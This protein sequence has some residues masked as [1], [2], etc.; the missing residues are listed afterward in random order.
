MERREFSVILLTM[1]SLSMLAFDLNIQQAD[2][3][4]NTVYVDDDNVGGPWNGTQAFPYRNI[5]SALGQAASGDTVFVY[6]GTYTEQLFVNKSIS[7]IGQNPVLT[8]LDGSSSETFLIHIFNTTNVI[9]KNF[10]VQNTTP[11][12]ESYGVS[13]FQVREAIIQNL[14][15]AKT[16]YGIMLRNSNSC[17][18]LGNQIGDT[19]NA[20]IVLQDGSSNNSVISNSIMD[21]PS[22]I[23]I[24]A[25]CLNNAFYRNNF[26]NNTRQVNIFPPTYSSWDNGAEGNYWNDYE[27]TD[28]DGDGIGDT[29]PL[30]LP[31]LGV[32][33]HPLIEPWNETRVYFENSHRIVVKCNY[34]VASF[35]HNDL[36]RQIS[37]YITGPSGWSGYCNVTI[38]M[39]LLSPQN[40]SEKWI[41]ML[42]Q[43]SLIF[44]GELINNSTLV[45]FKYTLGSSIF[46]NRVRIRVGALYPP[47][48]NFEFAPDPASIIEQVNFT[49]TSTES[50]NGTIVWRQWN[51]GDGNITETDKVSLTHKFE[52]K[53]VFSV[54]L[55]VR[56]E[57]NLT[58]SITKPVWIRNLDPFSNFTFTPTEPAVGLSVTFN[59]SMSND[60]DGSIKEYHWDFGDGVEQNTTDPSITHVFE[61][62]QTYNVTLTV[63]DS[64]EAEDYA[65]QNVPIGKGAT[66][67][68]VDASSSAK[69]NALFT[70]KATLTDNASQPLIGEQIEFSVY[71]NEAISSKNGVTDSDGAATV[72]FSLSTI[73]EYVVKAEYAGNDDYSGSNATTFIVINPMDTSLTIL[74]PDNATQNETLTV[75]ATLKDENENPIDAADVAFYLSNGTTWDFLATS[76][77]NQSGVALFNYTPKYTGTFMLRATFNGDGEYA[78]SSGDHS[79][80]VVAEPDYTFYI[81][82]VIAV[83]AAFCIMFIILAK[84]KKVS[85]MQSENGET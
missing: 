65:F 67:V 1:L 59:A 50:P 55:T 47:T 6:S 73:G 42:G 44:A 11:A 33:R 3:V 14:I 84:R 20:G 4:S 83:V 74:F 24:E 27:G 10:T 19:Y 32:D 35:E 53:T 5:T 41:V 2:A 75:F 12:S 56:D 69:V 51:F 17:K 72:I 30:S 25:Y 16:Y 15:V 79:F 36:E 77:T 31:H 18:V 49:D 26:V 66:A 82:L 40:T 85:M 71:E 37:F 34:T 23:Y 61:H 68:E 9:V 21:N 22:G 43:D 81:M 7:L 70:V 45:S 58:D 80:I 46:E 78:A 54:I 63:V 48:A 57:N 28:Q 52:N 76:K 64:D 8:I 38:P 29:P 39:E 62:A 13:L 60:A